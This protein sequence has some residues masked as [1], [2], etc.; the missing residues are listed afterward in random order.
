MANILFLTQVLPFPLDAGPKVRAYHMLRR[1][2][3]Q[4]AT[5]PVSF[6]YP[7]NLPQDCVGQAEL[8]GEVND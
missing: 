8:A 2:A 1:L 3:Q 6:I 4:S 7:T 5:T